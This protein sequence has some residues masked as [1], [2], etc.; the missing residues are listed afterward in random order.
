[1]SLSRKDKILGGAEWDR[2]ISE[3]AREHELSFFFFLRWGVGFKG[4]E[5]NGDG[6]GAFWGGGRGGGGL[7]EQH[8]DSCLVFH[9]P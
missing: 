8:Y 4:G 5:N 7:S 2:P 1:M 3:V 6:K 9:A